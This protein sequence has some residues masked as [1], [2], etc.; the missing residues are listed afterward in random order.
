MASTR[1]IRRTRATAEP[2]ATN[3]SEENRETRTPATESVQQASTSPMEPDSEHS[4]EGD[5]SSEDLNAIEAEK[6]AVTRRIKKLQAEKELRELQHRCNTLLQELDETIPA[7]RNTLE[8]HPNHGRDATSVNCNRENATSILGP[9]EPTLQAPNTLVESAVTTVSG[10]RSRVPLWQLE[11]RDP[12]MSGH[13][14]RRDVEKFRGQSMKEFENFVTAAIAFHASDLDYYNE[15]D[16]RKVIEAVTHFNVEMQQRWYQH[17]HDMRILP[18]WEEFV[19]W[20]QCQVTDPDKSF[21]DADRQYWKTEQQEDQTV[22][23]FA[24]HLQSIE[25]RLR[26]PY[27]EY[28]RKSHLYMKVL[29]SIR[30]EFDKYATKLEELSYDATLHKLAIAESNLPERRKKLKEKSNFRNPTQSFNNRNNAEHKGLKKRLKRA[31]QLAMAT[32]SAESRCKN[33][34]SF[35]VT[36]E[37]TTPKSLQKVLALVDSGSEVNCVDEFWAK[38]HNLEA[39][40]RKTKMVKSIDGCIMRSF[41]EYNIATTVTD[42]KCNAQQTSHS[43][44]AMKMKDYNLVLGFPWLKQTNPLIDWSDGQFFFRSSGD[45]QQPQIISEQDVLAEVLTG[46]RVGMLVVLPTE[47]S[48]DPKHAPRVFSAAYSDLPTGLPDYVMPYAHIFSEEAAISAQRPEEAEHRID[49]EPG[50]RPPFMPIYNLSET[51]L[52]ALRE[53]LKNALDKGWIQPSSSPAGAPILFVPKKDGGLRLCVDY[54]GL[55]RITIKNRYPLPLISEL[56]DRL[57]KAKVFT[58]LDL[59]DAYH[60]I[61]IAAKDRWK[62]AF[63]TRYGHFEYVVMPFGLANAPA[64]FQAYI[65][66]ALSDLLDICCV[67]YLDDI[68]IF[69]NSKQEHKVHVTKVLERLER[70]NLFAKLS[71]SPLFELTKGSKKGERKATFMWTESAQSAFNELKSRFMRAPL[72]AHFDPARRIQIEPDA[73]TFAVAAILSQLQDDGHWHPVAFWSRKLIDAETRYDT[74]DK[75]LLAIVAAFKNWR[76][77]L[78]GSQYPIQVWSDHANLQYFMTTKELNRRQA[79]WA[80]ALSAYDFVLLHRP[81][82]KNP[83][84]GPSRRADYS[85]AYNGQTMLPTL[86]QKLKHGVKLGWEADTS[87]QND[88][89]SDV[90]CARVSNE[91]NAPF[92]ERKALHTST[93]YTSRVNSSPLMRVE[94]YMPRIAVNKAILG[95][96]AYTEMPESFTSFLSKAQKIDSF[97]AEQREKVKEKGMTVAEN[98]LW[99]ISEDDILRADGRAYVPQQKALIDEIISANH[100][101]PQG[102]HFG[103]KKSIDSIQDKYYWHGLV[104]DVKDY[105]STCDTCQRVKPK[106]HRQY[107]ELGTIPLPSNPFESITMDFIT[108]LPASTFLHQTYD[109]ILVIV[110]IYTK[111]TIYIPCTK[112]ITADELA[113]IV[114]T[115]FYTIYGVPKNHISDRG[116]LFTSHYWSTFC[117]MLGARRKL[118]TAFHPQ[119]DGQTERQNQTLEHYLRCFVNYHQ[120]DWARWL[121]LAQFVY[122]TSQHASTGMAP[123][124]ALMGYRPDLKINVSKP[125]QPVAIHAASHAKHIEETRHKLIENLQKA[126]QAQKIYY[127]AKHKP[128]QFKIGDY[129]MLNAKNLR[130][131]RP[132]RKLDH[133]YVGPFKILNTIGKQAYKLELPPSYRNIHPV[134]HVSLLEPYNRRNGAL[135]EPGPELVDGEE[136]YQVEEIL[137]KRQRKN[138]PPEYLVRWTG[139]GPSGDTWEPEENILNTQAFEIFLEQENE[140]QIQNQH[141]PKRQKRESQVEKR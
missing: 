1:S 2:E 57:S 122:N 44:H 17:T 92:N 79:R 46:A 101:D 72:L 134:F 75:E 129:V 88:I 118:S 49:L 91:Q 141:T 127:D 16:H 137:E 96:S 89:S 13:P 58:K 60:R 55:N 48:K 112:N 124:E 27:S 3:T 8:A 85:E 98:M 24:S 90:V 125:P 83:A 32:I 131:L 5:T 139:W 106:R 61:L 30:R 47:C 34:L 105:I 117:Y 59:R 95:D 71:K 6:I 135:P 26:H 20:M 132:V 37:I 110:D 43:F 10:R 74:H 128:Q 100:D 77:Y 70:A 99:T 56:L 119:T 65:N 84:D 7:T 94:Q 12:G 120:D 104:R 107:G 11:L 68:L 28:H 126:R 66:N 80:E 113:E 52:A 39:A 45:E 78:E 103:I 69:S 36:V 35:N 25:G 138:K 109:A 116:S 9:P 73:S 76:H 50:A 53:Y 67:V 29:P 93:S 23:Q 38:D 18:P 31:I 87:F 136:E 86:Q 14:P 33:A 63:R 102:G 42:H 114:Y 22:Q 21:R 111:F 41:G 54:R 15:H 140:R 130:L 121:P 97:A 4:S 123:A 40:H 115:K 51:E 62:T 108:G 82:S 19:S 64:T 133:K 81:G